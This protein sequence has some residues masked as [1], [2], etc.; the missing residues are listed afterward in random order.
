MTLHNEI[1]VV[2]LDIMNIDEK[3]GVNT[4]GKR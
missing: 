4:S 2:A 1:D 3:I